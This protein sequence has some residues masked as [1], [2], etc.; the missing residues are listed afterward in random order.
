MADI[1]IGLSA[2]ELKKRT[3]KAY[4]STKKMLNVDAEEY[5]NLKLEDKK[6]LQQLVKAA[7]ILEEV[8]LIQDNP[9]N[10]IFRDFLKAQIKKGSASFNIFFRIL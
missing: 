1:K 7:F 9:K 6:A 4:L 3:G 2:K 10:L 5:K 8:Y